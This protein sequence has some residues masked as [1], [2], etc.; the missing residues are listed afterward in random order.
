MNALCSCP[1]SVEKRGNTY[2]SALGSRYYGLV[3]IIVVLT[4]EMAVP[5]HEDYSM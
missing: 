5:L 1:G 2:K 3:D 4:I